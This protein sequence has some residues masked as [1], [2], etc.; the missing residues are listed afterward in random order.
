MT[1]YEKKNRIK[2]A[3]SIRGLRQVE[4]VEKTGIAKGTINN[5][6]NQKYQP[7]QKSLMILAKALD[8]SE[9]WLAG[10][11][12]PMERSK[13][14]KNIDELAK[15]VNEIRKN[16][17]LKNLCVKLSGLEDSQ[18]ESISVLADEIAKLSARG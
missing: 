7:K 11:D 10:Y 2:E 5:W 16:D 4:L 8:V 3:L 1:N 13:E 15:L 9:I 18:L 17:K 14:Q 12:A 6:L